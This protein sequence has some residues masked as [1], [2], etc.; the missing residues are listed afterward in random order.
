MERQPPDEQI[1]WWASRLLRDRRYADY[2]AERL[3]RALVGTDEGPFLVFRR[4]RFVNWL[5]DELFAN[6]PYDDLV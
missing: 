1:P 3:A 6:R 5:S 4:R 2:M